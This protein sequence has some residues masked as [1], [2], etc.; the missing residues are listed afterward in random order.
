M[1]K[2]I[3][4]QDKDTYTQLLNKG[5][6]SIKADFTKNEFCFL[7]DKPL[8][9]FKDFSNKVIISNHMFF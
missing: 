4:C 3:Y 8:E 2:F 6:K 1:S 7:L 9:Q 5:Y